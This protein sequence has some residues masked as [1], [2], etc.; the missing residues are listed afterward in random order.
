MSSRA[1]SSYTFGYSIAGLLLIIALVVGR[2]DITRAI[3]GVG[4]LLIV[5]LTRFTVLILDQL[6][7]KDNDKQPEG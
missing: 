7:E 5:V 6:S 4:I 3:Y 1:K 2:E